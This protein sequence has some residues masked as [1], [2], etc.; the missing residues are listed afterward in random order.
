MNKN[1]IYGLL[2]VI[3]LCCIYYITPCND[4]F[5]V[6]IQ[7]KSNKKR[8]SR[9][10]HNKSKREELEMLENQENLLNTQIQALG[11]TPPSTPDELGAC[12]NTPGQLGGKQI[13]KCPEDNPCCSKY[14][15]CGS[16]PE[17]CGENEADIICSNTPGYEGGDPTDKCPDR[18]P[19]CSKLGYC[20]S[21]PEYCGENEANIIC[22][23]TP[24]YEGG[25]PTDKCP[26]RKPC[27]SKYGY[28]GG[29]EYV[30]MLYNDRN[31]YLNKI[32]NEYEPDVAEAKARLSSAESK[33]AAAKE[34]AKI[35]DKIDNYCGKDEA[36]INCSYSTE[37]PGRKPCCS[38]N[39]LC[40]MGDE[41]CNENSIDYCDDD[42]SCSGTDICL[43]TMNSIIN[44]K[45]C[46][47]KE[48]NSMCQNKKGIN[49]N[50][51]DCSDE[52]PYCVYGPGLSDFAKQRPGLCKSI[53]NG[54]M[55]PAT[56]CK[57]QCDFEYGLTSPGIRNVCHSNPL[58]RNTV[59]SYKKNCLNSYDP[60]E[61]EN[62]ANICKHTIT[63]Q[64]NGFFEDEL[65]EHCT[66]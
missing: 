51:S 63:L 7:D 54:S 32:K 66:T 16:G 40:G 24:G 44:Y 27:C 46:I 39:G 56:G 45:T 26:D 4:G 1:I 52:A 41:Y 13:I 14:G 23:S 18:K 47:K 58:K 35:N 60:T 9:K 15:Y 62:N 10:H 29:S 8:K 43:D 33:L 6:G 34:N 49:E 64:D 3:L 17:H 50:S 5:Q 55:V 65:V 12:S 19:C 2:I 57:V 30:D 36:D 20:G 61:W 42:S 31:H 21:G 22:S 53:P 38:K 37:C 28:C 11:K 48:L 25:E 59:T